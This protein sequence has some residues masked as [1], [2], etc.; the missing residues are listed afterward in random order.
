M[1]STQPSPSWRPHAQGVRKDR[2]FAHALPTF[3]TLYVEHFRFVWR[4]LQRL[5]VS[6]EQ[7]EDAVHDVFVVVHR[8]LP[9]WQ[10]EHSPKAW[11][12]AIARRVASDYRRKVRR[13]GNLAALPEGLAAQD[14]RDP[15]G[16]AERN[17]ATAIVRAFLLQLDEAHRE[18]FVLSELEQ[19]TAPEIAAALGISVSTAYSRIRSARQALKRFVLERHP[20]LFAEVSDG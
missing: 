8:R 19:M 13:K 17:Q 14:G 9:Q 5:G 1:V 3:R 6:S 16:A 10:P 4:N 2:S 15:D 12:F 11:L 20:D 7:L 18:V